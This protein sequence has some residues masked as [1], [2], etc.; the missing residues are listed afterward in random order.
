MWE[1]ARLWAH[2]NHSFGMYLSCLGAKILFSHAE[3]P[4]GS[5]WGGG[6]VWSLLDG[7]YSFLHEFPHGSPV[8]RLWWLQSLMTVT[9]FL[10]FFFNW[11]G[12]KYSISQ[13]CNLPGQRVI[14]SV[15]W[16]GCEVNAGILGLGA[17]GN[18]GAGRQR[19][20]PLHLKHQ[21]WMVSGLWKGNHLLYSRVWVKL[22]PQA[23]RKYQY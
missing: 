1:D 8:Y 13:K 21:A 7:R 5:L 20:R 14:K 9:S 19:N 22:G 3:F 17:Q 16:T 4:Q 12:S 11:Y 6:V 23:V 18:S 10:F 15:P 2:W